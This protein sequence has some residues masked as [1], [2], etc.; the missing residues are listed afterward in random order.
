MTNSS[1]KLGSA[2]LLF[3][4]L[5]TSVS[6]QLAMP[7]AIKWNIPGVPAPGLSNKQVSG[8]SVLDL[9]KVNK[10]KEVIV[11]FAD[12]PYS[13]GQSFVD[14]TDSK[15]LAA[16]ILGRLVSMD[17]DGD[18]AERPLPCATGTSSPFTISDLESSTGYGTGYKFT[19][20]K[21]KIKQLNTNVN[22]D[23]DLKKLIGVEKI[24]DL[25][26]DSL[27]A[28]LTSGYSRLN[29][30]EVE[31]VGKYEVYRLSDDVLV[32]LGKPNQGYFS[33]CQ[34]YWSNRSNKGENEGLITSIGFVTYNVEY[35]QN[36]ADS[37][38]LNINAILSRN[39]LNAN[40]K[41]VINNRVKTNIDASIK[42]GYQVLVWK[43]V[44]LDALKID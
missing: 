43:K 33:D 2:L 28:A 12:Q 42:R 6:A 40:S 25:L 13:P 18:Y 38:V 17:K 35:S 41:L 34:T 20:K 11:R 15:K 14:T 7:K 44:P 39:G 26:I 31:I 29:T 30:I 8:L 4:L 27:R 5:T 10:N 22:I 24:T 21:S 32:K 9:P 3:S 23:A 19:I 16:S 37:L 1:F 36:A